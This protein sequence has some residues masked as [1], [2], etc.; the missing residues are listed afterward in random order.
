MDEEFPP[1]WADLKYPWLRSEL[2]E[3]L[4]ELTIDDPLKLWGDQTRQGMCV[5]FDEV[6]HFLFDDHDFDEGDVGFS[7]LSNGE[8]QAIRNLKSALGQICD[9]LPKGNDEQSVSHPIWPEVQKLAGVAVSLLR[10]N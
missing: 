10:S 7:L 5:G 3:T 8:A 6:I 1:S 4:A 9:D 2:L